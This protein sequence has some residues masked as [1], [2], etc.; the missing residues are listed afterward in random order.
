MFLISSG[1]TQLNSSLDDI[2][3]RYNSTT[4]QPEWRERGAG[5]FVPF[6]SGSKAE[7]IIIGSYGS[8]YRAA[9]FNSDGFWENYSDITPSDINPHMQSISNPQY[10]GVGVYWYSATV[11][12]AGYFYTAGYSGTSG[13]TLLY[14]NIGDT[15]ICYGENSAKCC[16]VY[17]GETNPFE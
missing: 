8:G 10:G 3:I 17:F 16:I 15:L 2:D 1:L 6:S 9:I 13:S 14:K 7:E 11:K 4:G 12:K 5:S